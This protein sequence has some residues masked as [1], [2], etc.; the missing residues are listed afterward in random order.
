MCQVRSVRF[1]VVNLF[2]RKLC[3]EH[4]KGMS[5]KTLRRINFSTTLE[6]VD[7]RDMGLKEAGLLGYLFGFSIGIMWA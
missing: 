4:D 7:G 2:G 6:S 3:C 5:K 1:I